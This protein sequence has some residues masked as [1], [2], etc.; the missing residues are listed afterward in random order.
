MAKPLIMSIPHRLGKAEALRRLKSDLGSA[1]ASFGHLFSIDEQTW[2]GDRLAFR[3]TALGQAVNGSIDV[4]EDYVRL[5]VF[6]PW[7]FGNACRNVAATYPQG[8]DI[9]A[10]KEVTEC[11]P[12]QAT[13]VDLVHDPCKEGAVD[14]A[15]RIVSDLRTA[16]GDLME[17][18]LTLSLWLG[19]AL[20][21]AIGL[22]GVIIFYDAAPMTQDAA[23]GYGI[24]IASAS[25]APQAGK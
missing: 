2:T 11:P 24:S 22:F 6:L 7:L 9:V 13:R 23:G 25:A 14:Q 18:P 15:L 21:A 20:Y 17:N 16:S 8:R 19:V 12:I 10:G 4:A 1:G 5:E 3:V